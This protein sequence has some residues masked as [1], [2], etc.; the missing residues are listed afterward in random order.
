MK[1]RTFD[2]KTKEHIN[3]MFQHECTVDFT[4]TIDGIEHSTIGTFVFDCTMRKLIEMAVSTA[5]I[6]TQPGYRRQ[7]FAPEKTTVVIKSTETRSVVSI[8][9]AIKLSPDHV[10]DED[11]DELERFIK[12]KRN[13]KV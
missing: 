1:K 4:T 5:I 10:S 6:A 7:K 9:D 8:K 2:H 13:K 11:L 12:E 3:D